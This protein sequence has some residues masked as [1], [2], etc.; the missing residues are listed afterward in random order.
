MKQ[1]VAASILASAVLVTGCGGGS[2]SGTPSTAGQAQGV[3]SGAASSGFAFRTIVLPDDTFYAIYGTTTGNVLSI[4]GMMTGRGASTHGKYA[5]TVTDFYF[6]GAINSGSVAASYVAE[7]SISGAV[8]ESGTSITFSGTASAL[9]SFNYGVPA[10]LSDITGAWAG[11]LM[12]GTSAL[13]TVSSNGSVN[14]SDSGCSFSGSVTPDS[15]G[16]NFF[17]VSL[18]Y[19]GSPCLFPNQTQTGIAIDSL[20]SDGVTHQLLAGVTSGTIYG[21]VLVANR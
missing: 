16:K 7:T 17:R 20:L 21:T 3:F 8:T 2:N 4:D 12:D 13:V 18:T 1:L 19:G 5:A 15:S 10:V 11:T 9:S 14:G 6:T